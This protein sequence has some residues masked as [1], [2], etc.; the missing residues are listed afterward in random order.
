MQIQS[1]ILYTNSVCLVEQSISFISF[2]K[3]LWNGVKKNENINK[4]DL[5]NVAAK[6]NVSP[7]TWSKGW[8]FINLQNRSIGSMTH[9]Y[10]YYC[11]DGVS[12]QNQYRGVVGGMIQKTSSILEHKSDLEEIE[13]EDDDFFVN[14]ED[15]V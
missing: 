5:N 8:V 13:L 9:K 2:H 14:F 6:V 15:V 4:V 7:T 12:T 1:K 3:Y 11:F 10:T